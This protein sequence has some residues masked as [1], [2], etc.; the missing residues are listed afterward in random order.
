[1]AVNT[2]ELF[3]QHQDEHRLTEVEC[4]QMCD[5]VEFVRTVE[6]SKRLASLRG[7]MVLLSASGML[8]GGRVLHHLERVAPDHRNT[9]L[10]VGY[11]AAGTRGEALAAGTRSIKMFG[12]YVAVRCEV[13]R[14]DGLS[15]HAD[16]AELSNWLATIPA[17]ALGAS[18][19]H[20]EPAAADALR[21]RLR[22]ELG[23]DAQIPNHG[24]TI[25][26]P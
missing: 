11:Q 24:D 26:L 17:P 5:G 15:A 21:R 8:A 2:T 23:W 4:R 9:V 18:I 10:L 6:E 7:P 20:G 1:M 16:A 25:E 12:G 19:V 13:A 3:C 22:D 14:I